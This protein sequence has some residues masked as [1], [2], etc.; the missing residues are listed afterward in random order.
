MRVHLMIFSL[1]LA[2]IQ[3]ACSDDCFDAD[4]PCP[5]DMVSDDTGCVWDSC[6]GEFTGNK[7]PCWY[8]GK[9][10]GIPQLVGAQAEQLAYT[11]ATEEIGVTP[12]GEVWIYDL[13]S[14][15][16]RQ[17]VGEGRR[18]YFLSTDLDK[19]AWLELMAYDEEEN[20]W[21]SDAFVQD[22]TT[23]QI[24]HVPNV[25]GVKTSE[26]SVSDDMIAIV[27]TRS[28]ICDIKQENRNDIYL[29]D[30]QSGEK[31]LAVEAQIGEF[32]ALRPRLAG[33]RMVYWRT[34][35]ACGYNLSELRLYDI[36]TG[37]DTLV[38]DLTGIMTGPMQA[39]YVFH[40]DGQW[41]VIWMGS[42]IGAYEVDTGRFLEITKCSIG[43]CH[44][45]SGDGIVV[46]DRWGI[47]G[48]D[49]RQLFAYEFESGQTKQLTFLRPVYDSALPYSMRGHRLLWGEG[50]G[51]TKTDSCGTTREATGKTILFFWKDIEF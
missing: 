41:A 43:D 36:P 24:W 19:V 34:P 21:V 26:F 51:K 7:L 39:D 28:L 48:K 30:L 3:I 46:Y 13:N 6:A 44:T 38:A 22:I 18:C 20:V 29:Y 33:N 35:G 40:F 37:R 9:S 27:E 4:D 50:R 49:Q 11:K 15:E 1:L 12:M 16:H 2:T 14:G 10:I 45:Y 23:D 17:L 25:E 47:D 32:N 42:E 8:V 5:N 31:T